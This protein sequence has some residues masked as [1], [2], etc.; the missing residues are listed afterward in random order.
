MISIYHNNL[1]QK[2]RFY[3]IKPTIIKRNLKL[4]NHLIQEGPH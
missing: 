4:F 2:K 1:K 3:H